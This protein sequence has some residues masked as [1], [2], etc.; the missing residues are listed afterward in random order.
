MRLLFQLIDTPGELLTLLC[1]HAG[2]NGHAGLL[3]VGEYGQQRHLDIRKYLFQLNLCAEFRPHCL[4]QAQS[5]I[6]IFGGIRGRRLHRHLVKAQL[7]CALAGDVLVLDRSVVKVTQGHCI[8]VVTG[9]GT[10]QYIG[11]QHGVIANTG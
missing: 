5:H 8:H 11:L 2:I 6:G 9:R 7:L 10:L 1:Q 3:H 4:V